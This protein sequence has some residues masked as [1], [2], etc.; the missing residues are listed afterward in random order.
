MEELRILSP[1]GILGYGFSE[2]AF[3]EGLAK[4]PHLIAMDAG[5]TDGGPQKLG[6]GTGIVSKYAAKKDLTIILRES[7]KRKI[8]VIIG[9]AGGA[10]CKHGV[11]WT[12]DIIQEITQEQQISLKSVV[13]GAEIQKETVRGALKQRRIHALGP[14]PELNDSEVNDSINIVAQMG[15]EPYIEALKSNP[16]LIIGGRTYDPAVFAALG[17]KNNFDP[18][19]AWHMGKILECGALC[20][21]PGTAGDCAFGVLRQ[22]HFEIHSLQKERECTTFSVASHVLYEKSHPSIHY[23]PGFKLDVNNCQY[24]QIDRYS[25]RVSGSSIEHIPYTIKLEGVRLVGWRNV[26]VAGIRDP[27]AIQQI[28]NIIEH[29]KERVKSFFSEYTEQDFHLSFLRYGLDGVMGRHEPLKHEIPHELGIVIEVVAKN[30]EMAKA[31][32]S[33]ARS[34]M[35]HYHYPGRKATAGNLAVPF[36]DMNCGEVFEFNIYHLMDIDD[37]CDLFP[38]QA[39]RLGGNYDTVIK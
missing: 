5:S 21:T 36:P 34:S 16:D 31:I 32:C 27:I 14:V 33:F 22:D 2:Q 6:T 29:V 9:S 30:Q 25:V 18:A 13:I 26:V 35:M 1:L 3:Y 28:D 38:V 23:G 24:E 17:I 8:P 39:V 4:D 20:L 15:A 37:P 10:G 7:A 11:E 12:L 19:L